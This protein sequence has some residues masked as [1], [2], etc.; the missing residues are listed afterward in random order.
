MTRSYGTIEWHEDLK[1]ILR[2][3]A[4]ALDQHVVFLFNDS[5]VNKY[6]IFKNC[7]ILNLFNNNNKKKYIYID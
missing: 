7:T 1:L 6:K 5:E 4:S 3:A 2:R